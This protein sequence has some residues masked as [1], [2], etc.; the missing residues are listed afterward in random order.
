MFTSITT[1]A[2]ELWQGYLCSAWSSGLGR[3]FGSLDD[4]SS[5]LS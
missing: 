1:E 3:G 2:L 4:L 5:A